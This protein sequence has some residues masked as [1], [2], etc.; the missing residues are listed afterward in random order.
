[1]SQSAILCNS[2]A[3]SRLC[4]GVHPAACSFKWSSIL[5][6]RFIRAEGANPARLSCRTAKHGSPDAPS[7]A[8]W[9]VPSS[10][11][12]SNSRFSAHTLRKTFSPSVILLC[13]LIATLFALNFHFSDAC[14]CESPWPADHRCPP[15]SVFGRRF[16][17]HAQMIPCV[18]GQKLSYVAST[19]SNVNNSKL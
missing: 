14:P 15:A 9:R 8:D 16:I 12:I 7:R 10:V 18:V 17:F 2:V 6:S 1:M 3:T 5:L 11:V 19:D 4:S 13:F